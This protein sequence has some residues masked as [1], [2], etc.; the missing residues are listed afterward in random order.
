MATKKKVDGPLRRAFV[1]A[2]ADNLWHQGWANWAEEHHQLRPG[3]I[4]DQAP[5]T[6]KGAH[7][8][9]ERHTKRVEEAN[10]RSILELLIEAGRA[11]G[12]HTEPDERYA[13]EFGSDVGMMLAGTGVSWFDDHAEFPLK[14]PYGGDF[15][16]ER[17]GRGWSIRMM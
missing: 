14:V 12:R 6:P 2:L 4:E 11:D 3:R 10:G 17:A 5:S 1:R 8:L 7:E 15:L 9:A 13:M 16:V